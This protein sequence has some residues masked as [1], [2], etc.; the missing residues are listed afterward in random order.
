MRFNIEG[1]CEVDA[2][3]YGAVLQAVRVSRSDVFGTADK[4]LPISESGDA[5]VPQIGFIGQDYRPGGT[6][7]LGINPGGGG[8]TYGRLWIADGQTASGRAARLTSPARPSKSWRV[9]RR[10]RRSAFL[11]RLCRY[12]GAL[13]KMSGSCHG[14]I[15]AGR[16]AWAPL[17][18]K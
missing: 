11:F 10:I 5:L 3:L 15:S 13:N 12:C 17:P 7:L 2:G 14:Q 6:I 9:G 18:I 16:I 4:Q 8:D 1:D